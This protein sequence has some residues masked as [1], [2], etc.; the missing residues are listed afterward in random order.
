VASN[1]NEISEA[2]AGLPAG[3]YAVGVSGGADS[4]ALLLLL[5]GRRDLHLH[6]VHLNHQTRGEASDG[7]A[8]F[9]KTLAESR[10]LAATLARLSEI[11]TG[12]VLAN[13]SARYRQARLRLFER[14]VYEQK[15]AGVILA[16]HADDQ[17]ETVL[18][19]LLRGSSV[20]G[21]VG[22]RPRTTVGKLAIFRPLL[23]VRRERLRRFL[24][25]EQQPW[26]E[27]ASNASPEYLRNRL[28]IFLRDRPALTGALS[29]LAEA[30]GRVQEWVKQQAPTLD[31]I[32]EVRTLHDLPD[33]VA[34]EALRRWLI[35]QGAPAKEVDGPAVTRLL[36][37]ARDAASPARQQF[38]GGVVVRRGGGRLQGSYRSM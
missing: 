36:Q 20:A 5:S 31:G 37:M 25:E 1:A 4:V 15:L 17:A 9:V 11:E 21:L 19:R 18:Q 29:E 38:A 2:I 22:M 7:D 12:P 30:A 8:E 10:G 3:C 23:G 35:N 33:L 24:E 32:F 34:Q 26:R 14:V 6:V 27:D 28:R 16:H 13:P